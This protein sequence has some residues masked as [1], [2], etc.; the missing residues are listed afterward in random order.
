M[1]GPML[2]QPLIGLLLD[3]SWNGATT[4]SGARAYDAAAF[5]T[6]F[7]LLLVWLGMS[8]ACALATRETHARQAG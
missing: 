6:A 4:A 5:R 7:L 3:L 1:T 8:L 2:M